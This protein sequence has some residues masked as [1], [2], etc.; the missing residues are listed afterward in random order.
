MNTNIKN[1]MRFFGFEIRRFNPSISESAQFM[2]Q[3]HSHGVNIVLD[4]GAN[5]GQFGRKNL[6]DAGY[7]GGIV[8]FEPLSQAWDGL[9]QEAAGDNLWTV[10]PRM[11][12][13][14]ESGNININ[15]SQNSVS[16]SILDML[17][18]HQESAPE[19]KYIA[20]EAVPI[21][22]LDEIAP[23]YLTPESRIFLKI[24]TQGFESAV[25][26]GAEG[27]L[28]RVIGI[29]LELSLIPLYAGQQLYDEIISHLNQ[30]GFDLWGMST[31]FVDS[32]SGRT[33]QVDATFFRSL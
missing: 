19:S 1:L 2:R 33:L 14:A 15:V 32:E 9:S 16:S 12:I 17:P 6:R 8:S 11:A 4:V 28:N 7:R 20:I 29:Q 21:R 5:I 31:A 22:R 10:A 24:D 3:L 30:I 27:I 18:E 13:G 23:Q 25:L 26:Q